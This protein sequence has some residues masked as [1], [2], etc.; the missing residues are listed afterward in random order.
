VPFDIRPKRLLTTVRA[1]WADVAAQAV[2]YL[3]WLLAGKEVPAQTILPVQL[4]L[5]DTA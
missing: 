4:I 2:Q 3:Q 5:G 1:P